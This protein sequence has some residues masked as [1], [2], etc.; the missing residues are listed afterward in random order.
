MSPRTIVTGGSSGIGAEIARQAHADGHE[1]VVVSRRPGPVGRSV[2]L[3]LGTEAGWD[4]VAALFDEVCDGADRVDCWHAAGVLTP[5]GFAGDVDA[6]AYRRNVMLNSA[7]GQVVGDAF[8]RS[9]AASGASGSLVMLSSG[10][11]RTPYRG[12]SSYCA[13]KAAIDHWVRV[14]GLEQGDAGVSVVSIAPGVVDTPMQEEI[15]GT[16]V[17]DFPT[18]DRFVDLHESGE[19]GD[20]ADVARRLRSVVPGLASGTVADL[21]SL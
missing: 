10:A 21:R 4:G 11:A 6:Q 9:M 1:V 20:P 5:I 15:R 19:L 18:L 3:D 2:S 14:V 7:A 12:W 13:G 8:L 17:G 16:D